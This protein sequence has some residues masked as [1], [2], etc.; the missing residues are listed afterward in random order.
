MRALPAPGSKSGKLERAGLSLTSTAVHNQLG[1]TKAAKADADPT[2]CKHHRSSPPGSVVHPHRVKRRS[3]APTF[4]AGKLTLLLVLGQSVAIAAGGGIRRPRFEPSDLE[5]EEPGHLD[6]DV[7]VGATRGDGLHGN[8]LI[9]PDF[10]VDL[11]VADGLE[12]DVEGAF[13][14][15]HFHSSQAH[16]AS[17]A[18]WPGVKAMVW[19]SRISPAS[20]GWAAGV[21]LGPRLPILNARGIGFAAVA[22]GGFAR[23]STHLA[24]NLGGIVD[25]IDT[26]TSTHPTSLV[27]GLDLD[28]DLNNNGTWSF[29]G[30]VAA[31]HYVSDDPEELNATAG[32][33]WGVSR[34][35]DL[36]AIVMASAVAGTDRAAV[37]FGASP[38]IVLW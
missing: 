25:P 9:L 15:D 37:I 13:G 28:F 18:L 32:L 20:D 27:A 24:L 23:S 14:V 26:A 19:D 8:R 30:E 17:E 21:Q 7:Q 6:L 1:V 34:R 11:G 22:L 3:R 35:L 5:M 31:A 2:R 29:V 36:S 12:I 33:V 10:E 16:L 38:K 4:A